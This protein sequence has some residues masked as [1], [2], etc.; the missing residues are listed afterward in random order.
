MFEASK[1]VGLDSSLLLQQL[2]IQLTLSYTLW[3]SAM[4]CLMLIPNADEV[5]HGLGTFAFVISHLFTA[6]G[7]HAKMVTD[8]LCLVERL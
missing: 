7:R 4:V 1:C 3:I 6:G 8:L 5:L 2:Y